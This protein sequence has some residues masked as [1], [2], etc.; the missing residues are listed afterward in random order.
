VCRVLRR[1]A[2]EERVHDGRRQLRLGDHVFVQYG[3]DPT[4]Q[5]G[6]VCSAGEAPARQRQESHWVVHWDGTRLQCSTLSHFC[7]GGELFRVTYPHWACR[8]LLPAASTQRPRVLEERLLEAAADEHV[9]RQASQRCQAGWGPSWAQ[10]ADLEFCLEAKTGQR[11][12]WE[13]HGRA[14]LCAR[15]LVPLCCQLQ[16]R[17]SRLLGGREPPGFQWQPEPWQDWGWWQWPQSTLSPDAEVFVPQSR[18][19]DGIYQ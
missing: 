11:P 2:P 16:E 19:W 6:I 5:H 8:C 13:L 10:A 14:Q 18:N 17:P 9:A 1:H 7:H 4:E 12:P 3:W 15:Q